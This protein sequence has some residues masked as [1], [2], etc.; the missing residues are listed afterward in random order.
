MIT[1][2]N[3]LNDINLD[4]HNKNLHFNN[5]LKVSVY[6]LMIIESNEEPNY[7]LYLISNNKLIINNNNLLKLKSKSIM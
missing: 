4:D 3:Y 5:Q 7:K 2:L 1:N 6:L